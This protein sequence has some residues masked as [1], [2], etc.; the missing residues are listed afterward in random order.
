MYTSTTITYR[1]RVKDECTVHDKNSLRSLAFLIYLSLIGLKL[2]CVPA[3]KT[4]KK[5]VKIRRKVKKKLWKTLQ[6]KLFHLFMGSVHQKCLFM[7]W[8]GKKK[9]CLEL[10][11]LFKEILKSLSLILFLR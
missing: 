10:Q 6:H 8:R 4:E 5:E 9:V 3:H 2:C 11:H 1:E 7:K